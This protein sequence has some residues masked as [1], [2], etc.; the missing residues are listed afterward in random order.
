[1]IVDPVGATRLMFKFLRFQVIG[2]NFSCHVTLRRCKDRWVQ[3]PD[4][5]NRTSGGVG[6]WLSA[7][8]VSPPQWDL[9]RFDPDEH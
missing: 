4:A 3:P 9:R 7:M 8:S 5:E 6:G 2:N 1:V